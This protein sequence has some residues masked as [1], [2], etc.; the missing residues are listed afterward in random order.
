MSVLNN[1]RERAAHI[2]NT[3]VVGQGLMLSAFDYAMGR[4]TYM[5]GIIAGILKTTAPWLTREQREYVTSTIRRRVSEHTAGMKCDEATWLD[6]ADAVDKMAGEPGEG[7]QWSPAD[8]DGAVLFPA[9]RG[10]LG[11]DDWW[12]M[13]GSA[14][15]YD[16]RGDGRL[17]ISDY[18][19]L[20][21]LNL[22]TL[23]AKWR[24]NLMRDVED[25]WRDSQFLQN[26]YADD[27]ETADEYYVWLAGLEID[28]AKAKMEY[29][30]HE[31]CV[32]AFK[33]VSGDDGEGEHGGVE[34][35]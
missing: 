5:P 13:V 34:E 28:G 4:S 25:A 31:Y 27:S 16:Y 21:G 9:F 10:R 3:P 12:C 33:N 30:D 1:N 24:I 6:L 17:A 19:R 14:Q 8:V 15:R 11:V 32:E 7:R 26:A 18:R 2:V 35:E 23:N 20:V 22:D 29:L